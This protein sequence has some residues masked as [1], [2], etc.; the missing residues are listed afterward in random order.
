MLAGPAFATGTHGSKV[1]ILNL[2]DTRIV[3]EAYNGCDAFC[4]SAH[5]MKGINAGGSKVLKC[6]GQGRQICK[7]AVSFPYDLCK[8]FESTC[9][10]EDARTVNVPDNATL[11][12]MP[13]GQNCV[14]EERD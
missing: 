3:A 7:I 1:T 5:Q 11:R 2:T 6:H 10:E 8:N 13:K 12:V 4:V 9:P 14:I